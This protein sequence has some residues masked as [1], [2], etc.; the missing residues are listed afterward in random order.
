[1]PRPPK[2]TK[3]EL[4]NKLAQ[5]FR[6][7]GFDG[8]SMHALSTVTGLSKA[9]L[10]HHFPDGKQQMASEVLVGEGKRLQ[11]LV[12][13]PISGAS[14]ESA[15][16]ESLSGTAEF[17]GGPH[18]QC[19]LNSLTLG[20]GGKHFRSVVLETVSAWRTLL[21][22]QYEALGVGAEESAAWAS[23]ALDRIQGALV[24]CRLNS[25]RQP[26]EQCLSELEGDVRYYLDE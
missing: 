1:M 3:L 18:P 20:E 4:L 19:L 24:M 9:S 14:S 8:T 25:S 23:Y 13:A 21:A 5:V 16:L 11:Q 26:L 22:T 10:Y 2:Q 15:L 12:L 7:F 6:E 17:Y